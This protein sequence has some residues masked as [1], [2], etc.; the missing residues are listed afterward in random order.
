MPLHVQRLAAAACAICVSFTPA[1]AL[2][3]FRLA[4]GG[5]GLWAVEGA[6]I[7]Q[8]AGIFARHGLEVEAYGTA[9]AGETLRR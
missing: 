7:G 5:F 9:G 4:N 6:R 3:K 8:Q 2:E 1:P